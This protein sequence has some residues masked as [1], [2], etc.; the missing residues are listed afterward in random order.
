MFLSIA[1][2]HQPAT[3]L[4][5]LLHK[6]PDRVH[7]IDLAFGTA[8]VFYPEA[9]TARCE[10]AMVLDVDPVGL[11]RGKGHMRNSS[12]STTALFIGLPT[13]VVAHGENEQPK[14]RRLQCSSRSDT[15]SVG[16]T[17]HGLFARQPNGR[18]QETLRSAQWFFG[19]R[20]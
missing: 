10:A 9:H 4:G 19:W 14:P 3:D 7:E 5:F 15:D 2:T 11:V 6:H 8:L 16:Q 18:L 12:F 13:V 20:A 17:E 1:T